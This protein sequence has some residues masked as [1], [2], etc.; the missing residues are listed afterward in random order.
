MVISCINKHRT[1]LLIVGLTLLLLVTACTPDA[2]APVKHKVTYIGFTG[3]VIEVHETESGN[4][5][6]PPVLPEVEGYTFKGWSQ[7]KDGGELYAVD[8]PVTADFTLYSVW[9]KIT[10]YSDT[11]SNL[12]FSVEDNGELTV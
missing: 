7:E 2:V 1:V 3:D 6:T 10:S 8:T 5:D 12:V 4:T 11:A 9:E